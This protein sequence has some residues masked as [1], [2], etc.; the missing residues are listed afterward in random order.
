LTFEIIVSF[1]SLALHTLSLLLLDYIWPHLSRH[2][3]F[4]LDGKTPKA[5]QGMVQKEGERKKLQKLLWMLDGPVSFFTAST[6]SDTGLA[7][8]G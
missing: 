1:F 8:Q 7:L 5:K 6:L 3:H 4:H 2:I